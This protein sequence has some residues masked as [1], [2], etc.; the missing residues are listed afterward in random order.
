[1][2]TTLLTKTMKCV[3]MPRCS[4]SPH[5]GSKNSKTQ[6]TFLTSLSAEVKFKKLMLL[7]HVAE[8]SEHILPRLLSEKHP[9]WQTIGGIPPSLDFMGVDGQLPFK[10][11]L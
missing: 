7:L 8:V 6:C 1:M 11:L 4:Q 3:L 5:S 9:G 10:G 2:L